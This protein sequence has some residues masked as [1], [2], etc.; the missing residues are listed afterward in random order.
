MSRE[1][2][3][4]APG[5]RYWLYRTTLGFGT[6]LPYRLAQGLGWLAGWLWWWVDHPGRRRVA[7]N[8]RGPLAVHRPSKRRLLVRRSYCRFGLACAEALRIPRLPT[9]VAREPQ[10]QC[11]DPWH[12]LPVA[13]PMTGPKI[14]C[15][16]HSNWEI[17]APILHRRGH[18]EQVHI[19]A[20]SHRDPRID[21]LFSAHRQ[22]QGII[23]LLLDQAP[24]ASLRAL[25]DGA[26]LGLVADRDYTRHGIHVRLLGRMISLPIGPAALAVQTGQPLLPAFLARNGYTRFRIFFGRPLHPRPGQ[27]RRHQVADLTQ[28]LADWYSRC[29]ACA[30]DQWCAFHRIWPE[31][32]GDQRSSSGTA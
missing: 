15:T 31:G 13:G 20:M 7:A 28:R 8:L 11:C 16:Q 23:S 2:L 17:L 29:I 10:W 4:D 18:T 22:R 14:F 6:R 19:V 5:L 3:A 30:P 32:D 26:V 9:W 25:R 27:N 24:L 1:L 12:C 21:R